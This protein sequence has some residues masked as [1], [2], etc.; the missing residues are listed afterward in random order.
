VKHTPG[1]WRVNDVREVRATGNG[2]KIATVNGPDH[3]ARGKDWRED[4]AACEANA[5]L[6]AAAPRMLDELRRLRDVVGEVDAELIDAVIAEAIEP[7]RQR[8]SDN[9]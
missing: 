9:A 2:W 3:R 1:P 6:I 4:N 8:G 7:Q 5:H